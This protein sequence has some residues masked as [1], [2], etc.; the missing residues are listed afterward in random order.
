[1]RI[2]ALL[3]MLLLVTTVGAQS[4]YWG[5]SSM[6]FKLNKKN[7][8]T[9]KLQFR[10]DIPIEFTDG[11]KHLYQ[12]SYN[13]ELSKR[14]DLS[15]GYRAT[16][17]QEFFDKQ[18]LYTDFSYSSK[19]KKRFVRYD[20]R[21]RLQQDVNYGSEFRQGQTYFRL[22]PEVSF[23]TSKWVDPYLGTEL[24]YRFNGKNEFREFRY[25]FGLE[26][27]LSKRVDLNTQL[28]RSVELNVKD[29]ESGWVIGT[30]L[31]FKL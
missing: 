18:R 25:L 22:K 13:R 1:M 15:L 16:L 19:K 23:N 29:T 26:F 28:M 31:K 14:L 2:L 24:F 12:L 11:W 8:L 6:K 7:A 17:E 20:I 5:G 4:K 30:F 21:A 3:A 10:D 9:L 27:K